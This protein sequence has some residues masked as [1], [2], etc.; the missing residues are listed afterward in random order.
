[1]RVCSAL[2]ARFFA[3]KGLQDAD[4]DAGHAVIDLRYTAPATGA[5]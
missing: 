4:L 1:M 3:G 2:P 5:V